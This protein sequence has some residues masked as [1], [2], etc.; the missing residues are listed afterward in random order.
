MDPLPAAGICSWPGWHDNT[1]GSSLHHTALPCLAYSLLVC[2]FLPCALFYT[3]YTFCQMYAFFPSLG[4]M[5]GILPPKSLYRTHMQRVAS[6]TPTSSL[7]PHMLPRLTKTCNQYSAALSKRAE[8]FKCCPLSRT[9]YVLETRD[10]NSSN[11]ISVTEQANVQH[12][13]WN[14]ERQGSEI[15]HTECPMA[16]TQRALCCVFPCSCRN[17]LPGNA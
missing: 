17:R 2:R 9:L 5:T 14:R 10:S 6:N 7:L 16:I 13:E 1:V 11:N 8:R 15:G 3:T 12:S 4:K